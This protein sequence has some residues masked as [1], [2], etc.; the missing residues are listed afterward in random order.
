MAGQLICSAISPHS[1]RMGIEANAP[2]FIRPMIASS[3]ELSAALLAM[4]PDLIVV[5]STHW[6]TTFPWYVTCHDHHRGHCVADEAPDMI[7]GQLYDRPGDPQ[8]GRALVDAIK[9]AGIIAGRNESP[10][11][12]WDY[13]DRKSTRLNSSH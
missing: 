3:R 2:D 8:F 11:Y 1:P 12:H 7:P 5:N 13:G 10:H 6:I 9:A 4:K